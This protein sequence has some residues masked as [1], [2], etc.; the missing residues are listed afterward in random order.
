MTV[1]NTGKGCISIKINLVKKIEMRKICSPPV[2][3]AGLK[4]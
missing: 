2:N 4:C 3:M 1:K